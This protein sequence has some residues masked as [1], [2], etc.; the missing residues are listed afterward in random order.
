MSKRLVS[1]EEE[2]EEE[3]CS[4]LKCPP[5]LQWMILIGE[6]HSTGLLKYR[7]KNILR[8]VCVEWCILVNEWYQGVKKID[9]ILGMHLRNECLPL[10]NSIIKLDLSMATAPITYE[11]GLS[12]LTSLTDLRLCSNPSVKN[13]CLQRLG[14]QLISLNL[15]YNMLIK[16]TTLRFMTRLQT[17]S[18][19]HNPVI[20]DTGL[21]LLT[22]LTTLDISFNYHIT[23]KPILSFTHLSSL[24]ISNDRVV[25]RKISCLDN[26]TQLCI[27]G[28]WLDDEE[29]VNKLTST[30]N[31]NR[32]EYNKQGRIKK[33]ILLENGLT[34]L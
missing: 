27:L 26:L 1:E 14:G 30:G 18:I 5:E 33:I 19:S 24:S 31:Q 7:D 6:N 15:N 20:T 28:T 32:V 17:L 23:P 3:E 2:E 13:A 8:S 16:D 34:L 10:F 11:G 22:N 25:M 4:I 9:L 21:S 12:H 29:V